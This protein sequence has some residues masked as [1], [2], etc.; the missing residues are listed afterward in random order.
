MELSLTTFILEIINF[1]ILVWIL[2]RLFF[3]PIKKT[4]EMR[5]ATIEKSLADAEAARTAAAQLRI[6]YE[7]RLKAWEMEKSEKLE[8]LKKDLETER[9]RRLK[10][11]DDEAKRERERL[12]AQEQKSREEL[13]DQ[14]EREAIAQSL[15]FLAKLLAKFASPEVESAVIR[16]FTTEFRESSWLGEIRRKNGA[17]DQPVS[18]RSAFPLTNQART[19]IEASMRLLSID[20]SNVKFDV[21]PTL[22]AGIEITVGSTALRANLRDELSYFAKAEPNGS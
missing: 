18:I 1:L 22:L 19:E 21:D 15:A 7:E 17:M 13:R 20:P 2:K 10:A 5:R 11:I 12:A 4:L 3:A 14:Q 9:G 6:Q 16:E 8:E